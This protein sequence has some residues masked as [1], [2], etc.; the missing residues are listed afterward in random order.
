[1]KVKYEQRASYIASKYNVIYLTSKITIIFLKGVL[2][3]CC[4]HSGFTTEKCLSPKDTEGN[5]ISQ[6]PGQTAL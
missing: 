3:I 2:K 1:M 6:D 5:A 4:Y